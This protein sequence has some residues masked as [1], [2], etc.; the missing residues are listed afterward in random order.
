MELQVEPSVVAV[1]ALAL[2]VAAA[3]LL[4]RRN[5]KTD[6]P[7]VR[8]PLTA[9]SV[10]HAGADDEPPSRRL[11][12]ELQAGPQPEAVSRK[13]SEP[14]QESQS[15][16]NLVEPV[17]R[18]EPVSQSASFQETVSV[19][20][21]LI[22]A[23]TK[24]IVSEL[25]PDEFGSESELVL[26]SPSGQETA[27]A[28][29]E[30][31]QEPVLDQPS[32]SET[33]SQP[34]P[35]LETLSAPDPVQETKPQLEPL[36][37]PEPVPQPE[38]LHETPLAPEPL[39]GTVTQLES[40]IEPCCTLEQVY[41][42]TVNAV[43]EQLPD[44]ELCSKPKP[45]VVIQ[46]ESAILSCHTL[47]QDSEYP[48]ETVPEQLPDAEPSSEPKLDAVAPVSMPAS[49]ARGVPEVEQSIKPVSEL[50]PL[51]Q[52]EPEPH[53]DLRA[54]PEQLPGTVGEPVQVLSLRSE[55]EKLPAADVVAPAD[56][57]AELELNGAAGE[58]EKVTFT[59]GK[60]ANKMVTLMS[61]EELEEEQS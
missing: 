12:A 5:R 22:E 34:V 2:L 37:T 56:E 25:L 57:Q 59:P 1:T 9:A 27:V 61:K 3:V 11:A 51:V 36:S 40:A 60:K 49:V 18:S 21:P 44:A 33:V 39:P 19:P 58:D 53:N 6:S 14:V 43:P 30:P 23:Q 35:V 29:S 54:V 48:V 31:E 41:K 15:E 45:E 28:E 24:P 4:R 46:P 42:S 8:S 20:D 16:D 38:S 55:Q 50:Q 17:C 32:T 47:E 13:D 7:V 26:A 52:S 10:T